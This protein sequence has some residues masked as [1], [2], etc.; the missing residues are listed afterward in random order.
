MNG[1]NDFNVWRQRQEELLKEARMNRLAKASRPQRSRHRPIRTLLQKLKHSS[2]KF[3][4]LLR[5]L[6]QHPRKEINHD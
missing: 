3:S 6:R 1:L 4:K 5:R 2:E